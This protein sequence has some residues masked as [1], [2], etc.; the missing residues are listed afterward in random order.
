MKINMNVWMLCATRDSFL[1]E[2]VARFKSNEN[3]LFQIE[4]SGP[5]LTVI[6]ARFGSDDHKGVEIMTFPCQVHFAKLEYMTCIYK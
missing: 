3:T 1:V 4:Y 6:T 5:D 2:N